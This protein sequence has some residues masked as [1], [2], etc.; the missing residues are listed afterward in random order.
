MEISGERRDI[1]ED[2][3]EAFEEQICFLK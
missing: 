1:P 3:I 2:F